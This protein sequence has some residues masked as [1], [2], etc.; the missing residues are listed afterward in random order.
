MAFTRRTRI[1]WNCMKSKYLLTKDFGLIL[2][3]SLVFGAGLA[4]L[5]DGNYFIGWLGFA[6]LFFLGILALITAWRWA[7][8]GKVLAWMIALA[9]LLRIAA[10][11][12]VYI[13]LPID[14]YNVPDDKAGYVFTDAHRRDDQ[15][16]D[17][18][19]S[20][21][22]L[23][24]AFDK[25]YY[26]DQYGGLLAISALAYKIF[27]PDVHRPLLILLLAALTAALGVPFFYRATHLLWDERLATVS[28]WL[29]VLYPES[30]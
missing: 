27:S 21:K 12:A 11:V 10:G 30:V 8:G 18:A 19:S 5:Q 13:A 25:T 24:S 7:G 4:A 9:A 23:W 28:T 17:L 1:E 29:F 20:G 22:P 6:A 2:P 14:G 3:L 26:T 16:W 15:A